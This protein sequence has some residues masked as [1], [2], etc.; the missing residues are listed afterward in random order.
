MKVALRVVAVLA[1]MAIVLAVG[2]AFGFYKLAQFEASYLVHQR[3]A[4]IRV[5]TLDDRSVQFAPNSRRVSVVTFFASWCG[6]CKAEMPALSAVSRRLGTNANFY[7]IDLREGPDAVRRFLQANPP[8]RARVFI[9]GNGASNR[10]DM[11]SIPTTFVVSKSGKIVARFA[12]AVDE[13]TLEY[14]IA[15]GK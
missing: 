15:K 5:A 14:E 12:G 2:A 10:L 4:P 3:F 1:V 13:R 6:D 7:L 8:V 11:Y 9:D